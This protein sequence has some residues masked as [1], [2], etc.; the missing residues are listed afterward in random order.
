LR[1]ERNMAGLRE[2]ML[3]GVIDRFYEAAARPELWRS[4]LHECALAL[5]A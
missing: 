5:G 3:G 1:T 4:V 2:E